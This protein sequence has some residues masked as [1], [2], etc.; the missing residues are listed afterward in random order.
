MRGR[1]E[2]ATM[3]D[4]I[5]YSD[6]RRRLRE[7]VP[8]GEILLLGNLPIS[9]NYADAQL[10]FRQ[11]SSFL[12]F[13]GVSQA[14]L[15]LAIGVDGSETLYG[16]AAHPDDLVWF[17]PHPSLAELAE[18]ARVAA[19]GTTAELE[20]RVRGV[21][22]SGGTLHYLPPYRADRV[23]QLAALLGVDPEAAGS[24]ASPALVR[25]VVAQ[26]SVK[27]E[28]EV[29]EIEDALAVTAEM[30]RAALAAARP[31]VSEA[32]VM[33]ALQ[34]AAAARGRQ[35]SFS[36]I[37]TVRGEVLHNESYG[38]LLEAGKLLLIDSGAESALGYAGDITRT[39]P[40]TG[41]FA[42][43]QRD[44]YEVVLAAQ[45]AAIGA[46]SPETTNR[47][48]H[49]VAA[50]TI[51][52]GLREIGLMRGDIDEAVAAGAHA[53]FFPH[54]IGHMLGLDVHDMEDLGDV[55]GYP[56]GQA[57][58]TQF[59]LNFLRLAKRLEPGFVVTIEPGVYFI[60]ALIDRWRREGRHAEF[61]RY[62]RVQA[63][64]G[65]GGV[66]IEDDVL[67]TEDGS[68]AL[69]PGIPKSVSDLEQA[70]RA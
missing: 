45:L 6:R 4:A 12:Y 49:L 64:R 9:R 18:G 16:P 25:A 58:S 70:A 28:A 11:D 54:G 32:A 19:T 29:A 14:G 17:G 34:A 27:S 3:L 62:D 61:I 30:Y 26:R 51:A 38:N 36:P 63:F 21:R 53:L 48:V 68:R 56:E 22:S 33:A 24:G 23:L 52:S 8:G 69:G 40:V 60:P 59:G 65:F 5:T 46:I 41:R 13:T 2:E 55:V 1:G 44:I 7:A 31:G 50:R 42:P 57:R 67:I 10:P 39:F 35:L 20:D 43:E 47:D 15:A 37:V 66:R